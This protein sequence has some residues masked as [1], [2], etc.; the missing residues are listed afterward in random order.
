MKRNKR[1][2]ALVADGADQQLAESIRTE[3]IDRGYRT[4]LESYDSARLRSGHTPTAPQS[5]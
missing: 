5:F 2:L 1:L 4:D 3:L